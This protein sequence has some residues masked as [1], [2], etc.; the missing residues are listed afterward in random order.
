ML[1]STKFSYVFGGYFNAN[2]MKLV[3]AAAFR[4][5]TYELRA[6]VKEVKGK[7]YDAYFAQMCPNIK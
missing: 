1:D 5:T 4:R 2:E 6:K 7:E 3:T